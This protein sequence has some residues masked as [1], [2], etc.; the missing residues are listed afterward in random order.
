[1]SMAD[2]SSEEK[3]KESTRNTKN[4]VAFDA[5]GVTLKVLHFFEEFK[6]QQRTNPEAAHRRIGSPTALE[7]TCQ[8]TG[9]SRQTLYAYRTNK[10][11]RTKKKTKL[12]CPKKKGRPF[13]A[14]D[15]STVTEAA[16]DGQLVNLD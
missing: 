10:T 6:E 1:M 14:S 15:A 13:K 4:G 2:K 5:K 16:N 11:N 9:M 8:A 3:P 7:L 12:G